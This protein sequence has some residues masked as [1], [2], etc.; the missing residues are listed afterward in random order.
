MA[1]PERQSDPS[2]IHRLL[3][4]YYDF[5]FFRAVRLLEFLYRPKKPLGQTLSP[6]EE[7]VR[8]SV[9]PGFRF[10]PSDIAHL[11]LEKEDNGE[12]FRMEV[13]FLGLIGPSGVL[14]YWINEL[15]VERNR[16]KDT[17]LTDFLDIFHHRLI[18]LFYLAWK[19]YRFP[20]NYLPGGKDR[21]SRHI[22]CLI[23]LGTRGLPGPLDLHPESLIFC[24]GLL[25]RPVPCVS[26][27]ESVLRYFTRTRVGIEQFINRL[28]PVDPEDQT[29]VGL[30]NGSLGVN[31]V[32]GGY[33]W[34]CQ[35][36][37]R[38]ELGPVGYREFVR[39]LPSGKNLPRLFA[40][41][42]YMAGVEY[43]FEVG[44]F[45]KREEVPACSLGDPAPDAPRLGWSTWLKHPQFVHG[46]DPLVVFQNP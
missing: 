43:E 37:F 1:S 35:S 17:S 24:S 26:A 38:V 46:E 23:G 29:Q 41:V 42:R 19:R 39:F 30:A 34:E 7:P 20:E 32:C 40:L 9:K 12:R 25:S 14:P 27:M 13:A 44:V 11:A 4:Q 18:S 15:A 16:E 6:G 21:L 10:P 5:S 33:A 31:A 8:F 36:K 45:L 2:L 28:V 22:L 3:N